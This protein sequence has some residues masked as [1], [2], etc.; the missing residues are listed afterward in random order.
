MF[1]LVPCG[2]S[3]QNVGTVFESCQISMLPTIAEKI[4]NE[5]SLRHNGMAVTRVDHKG[6]LAK[7]F[8]QGLVLYLNDGDRGNITPV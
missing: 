5:S 3:T 4:G 8:N 7:I 1:F 2:L 6:K